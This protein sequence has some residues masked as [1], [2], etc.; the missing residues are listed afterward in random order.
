MLK[1]TCSIN[2]SY[3]QRA[4]MLPCTTVVA[5]KVVFSTFLTTHVKSSNRD[6]SMT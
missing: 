6:V 4:A 2:L 3:Q 1:T 5:H